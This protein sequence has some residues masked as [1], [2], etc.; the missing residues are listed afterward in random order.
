MAEKGWR[1]A[2]TRHCE[3]RVGEVFPGVTLESI[4]PNRAAWGH[5]NTLYVTHGF[6]RIIVY[7]HGFAGAADF[8]RKSQGRYCRCGALSDGLYK[9][10]AISAQASTE[11]EDVTIPKPTSSV[12]VG[13]TVPRNCTCAG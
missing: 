9:T 4:R 10:S 2:E 6:R 1:S 12:T 3:S 7:P 8:V 5:E 13:R 11:R